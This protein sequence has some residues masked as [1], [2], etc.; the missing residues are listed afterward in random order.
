MK[1]EKIRPNNVV[2]AKIHFDR[3]NGMW[4][5]RDESNKEENCFANGRYLT[6]R[7]ALTAA[8]MSK[9]F[10]HYLSPKGE[11][12]VAFK[13]MTS[14]YDVVVF[15]VSSIVPPEMN[16]FSIDALGFGFYW[17]SLPFIRAV[18]FWNPDK[19][20]LGLPFYP[21]G[22]FDPG[23]MRLWRILRNRCESEIIWRKLEVQMK[24]Q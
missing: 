5:Y 15:P 24:A 2:V 7:D 11:R 6:R 17:V 22:M 3:I 19:K 1:S 21:A 18:K 10:T 16:Y 8:K 13:D 23:P 12:I 14:A 20:D 9:R 4:F